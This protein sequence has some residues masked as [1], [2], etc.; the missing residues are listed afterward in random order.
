MKNFTFKV[1]AVIV[2]NGL[3]L[4]IV[5]ILSD[6]LVQLEA[7]NDGTLSNTTYDELLRQYAENDLVFANDVTG[8]PGQAQQTFG[9]MLSTFSESVQ[10]K[11]L[12][13]KQYLDL[14][15]GTGAFISTPSSL[16]PLIVAC[17]EHLNDKNPPHAIT[18]YRWHR[19]LVRSQ[20]DHRA[21]IDRHHLKGGCG[22]RLDPEVCEV[23][24]SAID[25]IY[26]SEQRN[27]GD[28]V[29][30]DVVHRITKRNELNIHEKKLPIPSRA[31]IYRAIK[32]LDK[33]DEMT[34][35]FGKRIADMKFRTSGM[36]V[37]PNRV[38]E[39]VEIDHT[40][41]DL[42]IIDDETGLPLGRP[43][44]TF[45]IDVYTKMTIGMHI[46][47]TGT[48]IE[49]V[50]ACL[51]HALIPKTYVKREYPEIEN[52]WPCYGHIETLVCDNGLEF[53]SNELERVAFELGTQIQYCPK[54]QAYYKGSIERYLKT[55]NFQFSRSFPGHS[56]AKWFQR[57]DYDPLKH[58]VLS[59]EQLLRYLHRWIIDIYS[60]KLH[61]GIKSSPYRKWVEGANEAP[62]RLLS[63]LN[64][65][66]VTLG[67]TCERT[68][69]HYGVE[70][71]NL[72]YNDS[73]LL[74]LRRQ[75]G[76]KLKVEVRYYFEDISYI[77]LIDP[78]TK[79]AILVPALDQGYAKGL[80]MEQ[81]R[82]ICERTR[83]VNAGSIDLAA[84]ARAKSEIR[85]LVKELS[86]SKLQHKRTR[87]AK[88][89]GVAQQKEQIVL[90]T[91]PAETVAPIDTTPTVFSSEVKTDELPDIGAIV[92]SRLP[93]TLLEL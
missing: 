13:K 71:N 80:S 25:E 22:S 68:V 84:L 16:T 54:R 53:H 50:F 77:H 39:R 83:Q 36:G 34:A 74:S 7:E 48:S 24:Q 90:Q 57:E 6:G 2:I 45:A 37:R 18:V 28:D 63:D 21:L 38:L 19:G 9:R 67:R 33:H 76:E 61:R 55:L 91:A 82:L 49:A 87:A 86:L 3:R 5:R 92:F 51:R 89:K 30:H 59:F 42:F 29:F 4:R 62:P 40:P 69:F 1:G 81:H 88:I 43:T 66:D 15:S 93:K 46:G 27:S 58:A 56:F 8:Q 20:R 72:R 79:E 78:V 60:Q 26:L 52:D 12:R 64:R 73:A 47:F 32:S 14:I 70:L 17:A 85:Q 10:L 75:H 35:R 11:A 41:L 23:V 44:V 65:L 31:T